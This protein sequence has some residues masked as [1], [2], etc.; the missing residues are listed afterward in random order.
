MR[1]SVDLGRLA[2]EFEADLTGVIRLLARGLGSADTTSPDWLSM[3]LLVPE[4]T[5]RL[6]E[7]GHRDAARQHEQIAN[8]LAE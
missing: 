8:F 5:R 4:Y 1:P 2:G 7:I 3:L 6:I